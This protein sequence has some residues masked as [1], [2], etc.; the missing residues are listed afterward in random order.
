M[1]D[2]HA[3][4]GGRFQV[5][6]NVT[7]WI[8]YDGFAVRGQHVGSVRQTTE[9]E[10]FKVHAE[11]PA[12]DE[13]LEQLSSRNLWTVGCRLRRQRRDELKAET[14]AVFRA[15]DSW[16]ARRGRILK[17]NFQQVTGIEQDACVQSH[18]TLAQF[19]AASFDNRRR[20][21]LGRDDTDG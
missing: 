16:H 12:T 10:L 7:L 1:A 5:E 14:K 20:K 19:C 8:D 21:P 9:V 17:L 13:M 18:P 11:T 4:I 2:G 15:D 6:F 3:L